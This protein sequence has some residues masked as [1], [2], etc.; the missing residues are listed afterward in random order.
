MLLR[1]SPSMIELI[2]PAWAA[3]SGQTF[4]LQVRRSAKA[5]RTRIVVTSEKVEVVAPLDVSASRI[6]AFIA[7]E[8]DWIEKALKRVRSRSAGAGSPGLAPSDYR[9][10]VK[11][12]YLGHMLPLTIAKAT[13]K[14]LRI[15]L[16]GLE[17]FTAHVPHNLIGDQSNHIRAGLESWMK[18]Q[19]RQRAQ[20]LIAKHADK[21]SLYP[22]QLRIKTLRSRWGSCGPNNDIN[23]N[24][25]LMLAPA[26]MLE[27]VVV[28]ELCHIRHKNHSP[29]FWSLVAAHMPEYPLRRQWLKQHGA[30]VMRGL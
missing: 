15:E 5:K 25:L 19:A 26:E 3:G 17:R 8:Q 11:V 20:A 6:Q 27:Y 4:E 24:W 22:R 12:P 23:L 10:G 7:A 21:F 13:T 1:C 30:G 18:H 29:A 28:H 16:H 14:T 2:T 9:D